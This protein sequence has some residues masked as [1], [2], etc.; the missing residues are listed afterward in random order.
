MGRVQGV[1]LW[2]EGWE[3]VLQALRKRPETKTVSTPFLKNFLR[4]VTFACKSFRLLC[5]LCRTPG[6]STTSRG[7][8]ACIYLL[9]VSLRKVPKAQGWPE[10]SLSARGLPEGEGGT[11]C[12]PALAEHTTQIM[13]LVFHG[14]MSSSQEPQE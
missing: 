9:G 12:R 5:R 14:Q 3:L 13:Y 6:V 2:T 8:E 1:C 4:P 7:G 10:L 11:S